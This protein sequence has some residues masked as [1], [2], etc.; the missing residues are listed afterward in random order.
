MAKTKP[1]RKTRGKPSKVHQLPQSIKTKLD[2]LLQVR[3]IVT[4][5]SKLDTLAESFSKKEFYKR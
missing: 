1:A 2:E 3:V 5:M 4:G